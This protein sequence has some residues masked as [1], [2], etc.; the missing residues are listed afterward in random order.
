MYQAFKMVRAARIV[1]MSNEGDMWVGVKFGFEDEESAVI[2]VPSNFFARGNP[3]IGDFFVAYKDGYLSW[4]PAQAFKDGYHL[5]AETAHF[6]K[7]VEINLEDGPGYTMIRDRDTGEV[8]R[9][10]ESLNLRMDVTG[11]H[12]ELHMRVPP[13]KIVGDAQLKMSFEDLE[14]IAH[15][16][17]YALKP[18]DGGE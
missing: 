3:A 7:A 4:S 1:S 11:S 16:N 12:L 14:R 15:A 8:V 5:V 18:L 13:A 10:V 9:G 2:P 17:G 6:P